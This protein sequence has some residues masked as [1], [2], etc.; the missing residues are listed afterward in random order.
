MFYAALFVGAL[1][2]FGDVI[3]LGAMIGLGYQVVQW[4]Q[5]GKWPSYTLGSQLGIPAD[6][7]PTH[8]AIVDRLI[9]TVL[10]D[11]EAAFVVLICAGMALPLKE[12][13]ERDTPP[14]RRPVKP[15]GTSGVTAGAPAYSPP[16]PAPSAIA[17]SPLPPPA[18]GMLGR[19]GVFLGWLFNAVALICAAPAVLIFVN[20]RG[21]P[22]LAWALLAVAAAVWLFGRGVRYVFVGPRE[23][24]GPAKE[25]VERFAAPNV[26]VRQAFRTS[27]V[28][29]VPDPPRQRTV[30]S[31]P[32][33]PVAPK[34]RPW[35]GG[36]T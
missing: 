4:L 23:T 29:T 18:L 8:W 11:V 35:D 36:Q 12:W 13:L 31:V 22:T 28:P 33:P 26:S 34:R 2:I 9:H 15:S 21:D 16:I 6:L 5:T 32:P 17:S 14:A 19:L 24:P 3:A 30:P 20:G 10:F 7:Q 25:F 1:A 27:E